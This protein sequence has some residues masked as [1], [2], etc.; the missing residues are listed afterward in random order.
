[1]FFSRPNQSPEAQQ[2][3]LR[4]RG[5]IGRIKGF[6]QPAFQAPPL[7]PLDNSYFSAAPF[8]LGEGRAM[9]FACI[10]VNP[11]TG[12][13]GDTI[14]DP[15]YLRTAMLK[16]MAE[17]SDKAICFDFQIQVRDA[18]SLAGK[19]EVDIEDAC[20][21]WN[22]PF[23]TVARITI[24]PQ[25]IS[26]PERQEFCETLFYTPWHGLVDHRPLGGINRMRLK[27]YD[28]SAN[29]RGCPVSPNLPAEPSAGP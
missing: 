25:D 7:S 28:V 15:D 3:T 21:E 22:E 6:L 14:N 17:A 12:D 11:V 16:R 20:T 26:S 23:V 1:M 8:L 27:V 2:R 18:H 4:S 9:K 19:I 24:P 13:L 5:I 29:R 10:P